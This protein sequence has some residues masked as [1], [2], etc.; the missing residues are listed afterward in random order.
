MS[1]RILAAAL[2]VG[3][4]AVPTR[5]D[6]PAKVVPPHT[7]PSNPDQDRL[8]REALFL[9]RLLEPC[10]PTVL[11]PDAVRMLTAILK[12][13]RMGPGDGWFGP[14][15]SRH[16]WDWLS[17]RCG[18]GKDGRI[19]RKQFRGPDD[20][21]DRLDRDRDGALTAEDFDWSPASPFLRQAATA[22]RWFAGMD[23]DSNGRVSRKEW[24]AFF[25][26]LARGK[27]HLTADDL[28]LSLF[29]PM[30]PRVP[31]KGKGGP[32]GPPPGLMLR[33]LLRGELGSPYEGPRPGQVAPD[34]TLPT[35]DGK[36]Q[37]TL[38]QFRGKKPVVLVFGSFT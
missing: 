34:F 16:G 19:T 14:S 28:R 15:K 18:T 37:V 24:E 6:P 32:G 21:F 22:E 8:W 30:P 29:P 35:H 20:L 13:S 36:G 11:R 38:S 27:D 1:S 25:D 9:A 7:Q 23:G 4:L 10:D 31:A 12:G 3:W 33:C 26:R 2:A 17:A 5:A